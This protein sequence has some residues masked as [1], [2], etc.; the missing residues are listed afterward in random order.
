MQCIHP[1][2]DVSQELFYLLVN[3]FDLNDEVNQNHHKHI[4]YV[5]TFCS[6][7]FRYL[8]LYKNQYN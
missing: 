1:V 5:H 6:C 4:N 7:N 8:N 2:Y 3:H